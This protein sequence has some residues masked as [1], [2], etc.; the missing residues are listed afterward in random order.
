MIIYITESNETHPNAIEL[1]KQNGHIITF[2]LKDQTPDKVD[3]LFIRTYTIV[4]KEYLDQFPN[5]KYILKI[6]VGTDNIDSEECKKRNITLINA[7]GSNANAVAEYVIGVIIMGLRNI[8]PQSDRLQNK[9]WREK[10]LIGS[11]IKNKT[12]GIVGCGAIGKLIAKKLQN[13]EVKNILGY[14]PFM[15]AEQMKEH[16]IEKSELNVLLKTADIITL[17]LPL[18]PETTNLITYENFK[19]M[20]RTAIL[21]NSARGGIVNET[22]L[23]R[24]L[25]EKLIQTAA[26]DVF[27]N[28]PTV[29][30]ELLD[31]ENIVI[32]P[33]IAGYTTEADSEM[34]LMP[35]KKLLEIIKNV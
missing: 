21:I 20:K 18:T 13:F 15:T 17:H 11:E 5:L 2:D 22:D 10:I 8:L 30:S 33:H 26:L 23:V 28:E 6:G 3:A 4:T 7:P 35:V 24:A 27:E 32:T 1:L 16:N 9:G 12:V 31:L 14:D 19:N 29:R 34:S 25:Q